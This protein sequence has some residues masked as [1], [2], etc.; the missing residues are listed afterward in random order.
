[1]LKICWKVSPKK[2]FVVSYEAADWRLLLIK[3]K[4]I[5]PF[6]HGWGSRLPCHKEE[7]VYFLPLSSHEFWVLIWSTS[8]RWKA[9]CALEPR[10]PV[11]KHAQSYKSRHFTNLKQLFRIHINEN[12]EISQ[13]PSRFKL[14]TF[15]LRNVFLAEVGNVLSYGEVSYPI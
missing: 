11:E 2:T 14:W 5:W 3:I 15:Y 12:S 8:E 6:F 1:M 9:K 7:T 13:I 4:K 10:Y